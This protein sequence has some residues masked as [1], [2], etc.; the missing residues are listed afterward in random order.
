M[1]KGKA[2]VHKFLRMCQLLL[3]EHWD[4]LSCRL[5]WYAVLAITLERQGC[6]REVAGVKSCGL[7]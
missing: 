5:R 1:Q 6:V 4:Q 3:T 2:Q 7:H